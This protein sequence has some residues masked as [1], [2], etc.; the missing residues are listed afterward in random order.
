MRIHGARGTGTIARS[1]SDGSHF[2]DREEQIAGHIVPARPRAIDAWSVRHSKRPP[3]ARQVQAETVEA[4]SPGWAAPSGKSAAAEITPG[5][6]RR[7]RSST[8]APSRRPWSSASE[9]R[10]QERA[11]VEVAHAQ[12]AKDDA[13]TSADPGQE[14]GQLVAMPTPISSTKAATRKIRGL[15]LRRPAGLAWVVS[16]MSLSPLCSRSRRSALVR[17][18]SSAIAGGAFR[19]APSRCA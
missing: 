8:A 14:P 10:E 18:L 15:F 6:S 11:G 5:F 17:R 19:T 13:A 9:D 7:I 16:V 2:D 12:R 3:A 4:T 1:H